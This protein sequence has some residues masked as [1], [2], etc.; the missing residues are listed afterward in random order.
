MYRQMAFRFWNGIRKA[1]NILT[2]QDL[3]EKYDRCR[4]RIQSVDSPTQVEEG[5]KT[6]P[7]NELVILES[8]QSMMNLS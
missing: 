8:K 1:H 2:D 6:L 3:R 5:K 4:K 7:G